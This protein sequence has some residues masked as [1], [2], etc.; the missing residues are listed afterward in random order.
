[1][2][3]ELDQGAVAVGEFSA[4]FRLT[5]IPAVIF[6]AVAQAGLSPLVRAGSHRRSL[7]VRLYA[8]N[9]LAAVIAAIP[10]LA[11]PRTLLS[12]LFGAS[13]ATE[14]A[15]VAVQILAVGNLIVSAVWVADIAL[16]A[17][18]RFRARLVTSIGYVC[19][20]ILGCLLL[21]GPLAVPGA[22]WG[23]VLG[24]AV[25]LALKVGADAR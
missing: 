3:L 19:A 15:V 13:F 12:A 18:S 6:I 24:Y 7:L 5:A 8:I 17:R 21:V 2:I 9:A 16:V 10:M 14:G 23:V 20:T 22:A 1:M 4:A 25:G 11:F